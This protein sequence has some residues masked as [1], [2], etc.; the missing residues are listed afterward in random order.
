MPPNRVRKNRSQKSSTERR[1]VRADILSAVAIKMVRCSR[2]K[3]NKIPDC[4]VP[5]G[6][7]T[8][9]SCARVGSASC[10]SFGYDDSAVRHL[11][12]QKRRLDAKEAEASEAIRSANQA[13]V[14]ALAK[15]ERL[16]V[17]RLALDQKALAMF[18]QEGEVLAEQERQEA[19]AAQPS[20]SSTSGVPLFD[21]SW[22][23][24]YVPSLTSQP[25]DIVAASTMR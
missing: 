21:P 18:E 13:L 9:V 7:D 11:V 3:E 14:A 22:V 6:D 5:P 8:C 4:R 16:R 15:A 19:A 12:D 1:R 24:W 23:Q 10:D 17:Q 25:T 2:C 20:S